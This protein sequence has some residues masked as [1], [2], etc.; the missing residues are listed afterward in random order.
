LN[1]IGLIFKLPYELMF[2]HSLK[3]RIKELE[4]CYFESKSEHAKLLTAYKE[5]DV[6]N[7]RLASENKK[8]EAELSKKRP[9][10]Y[11]G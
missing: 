9:G 10:I 1:L 3:L 11:V 2:H 8:L 5:L 7:A 6:E 4:K